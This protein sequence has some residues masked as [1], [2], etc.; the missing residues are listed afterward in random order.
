MTYLARETRAPVRPAPPRRSLQVRR[1]PGLSVRGA[2]DA[3]GRLA[4]RDARP[5]RG[6]RTRPR[7][8]RRRQ[9]AGA[10]GRQCDPATSSRL[11]HALVRRHRTGLR[12]RMGVG[13]AHRMVRQEHDDSESRPRF[14]FFSRRDFHRRRIRAD[15]GAVSRPLRD[16][17]AMPRSVSD[18]RARRRLRDALGSLH[19]VSDDRKSR[20]DSAR[21]AAQA[22]QL[23]L[24]L[25]HLQRSLSVESAIC[26]PTT[27]STICLPRLPELLA[28]DEEAIRAAL[29]GQRGQARQAA[30]A[31]AQRRGRARQHAKSRR[32]A[33][34]RALDRNRV[35]A[36][37]SLARRMGARTDR[38]Q[39]GA[40]CTRARAAAIATP[41]CAGKLRPRSKQT[42]TTGACQSIR[43]KQHCYERCARTL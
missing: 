19:L 30:R 43:A 5:N 9:E 33:A 11:D 8:S 40:T 38:R 29:H 15:D 21:A 36:V 3:R 28:L 42:D 17:P 14:V 35:R 10:R 34:A 32:G 41:R 4:R 23:D 7:L 31:A 1:E 26:R 18:R 12:A 22:R 6:V 39:R 27:T 25:R 20:R 13:F 37:D 16:L 24:R 2:R